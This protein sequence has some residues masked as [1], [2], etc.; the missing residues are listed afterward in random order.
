MTAYKSNSPKKRGR[1]KKVVT[2]LAGLR[3]HNL[4]K[5][6]KRAAEWSRA[7]GEESK[8]AS[9]LIKDVFENGGN[10][11]DA[12]RRRRNKERENEQWNDDMG[13]EDQG[14]P[15]I[16]FDDNPLYS[17]TESEDDDFDN[18]EL[19]E[20]IHSQRQREI[21]LQKQGWQRAER[22]RALL[23]ASRALRAYE[24]AETLSRS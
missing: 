22:K 8:R 11:H 24:R 16:D 1:P 15:F 12:V 20:Q 7:A 6:K 21:L 10:I 13:D 17:E 14:M 3:Q 9:E 4:K 19:I 23:R 5:T 2:G 18:E